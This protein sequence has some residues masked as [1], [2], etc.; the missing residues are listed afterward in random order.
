MKLFIDTKL[1][2][3]H[4]SVEHEQGQPHLVPDM[5]FPAL[6]K[7]F[8]CQERVNVIQAPTKDSQQCRPAEQG[9]WDQGDEA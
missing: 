7:A 3:E 8:L 6:M 5:R 4:S 1:D 9:Q 2:P